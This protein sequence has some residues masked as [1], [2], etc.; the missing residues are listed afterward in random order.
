MKKSFL[1]ILI[2]IFVIRFASAQTMRIENWPPEKGGK[3]RSQGSYLNDVV[4]VEHATKAELKNVPAPVKTGKWQYW[5]EGG[6]LRS[7]ENFSLLGVRCGIQRTWYSGGKPESVLDLDLKTAVYWYENGQK[8][9]EGPVAAD[10]SPRGI[11]T[12]WHSNGKINFQGSYNTDG[13]KTG[14]WRF[15]NELGKPL[16]QQTYNNGVLLN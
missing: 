14:T 10:G 12:A 11:W 1:L 15:W 3:I 2:L 5:G 8:Q 4:P 7:E 9:S 6:N 16:A 13:L